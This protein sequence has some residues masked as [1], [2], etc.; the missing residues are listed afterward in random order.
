MFLG[1]YKVFQKLKSD[2]L[3]INKSKIKN[4]KSNLQF[5]IQKFGIIGA[6]GFAGI[7]LSHN[8]TALI[9][10]PFLIVTFLLFII[11]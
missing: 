4:Q 1:F 2:E 8:L 11:F 10:A 6:L 5:K 3:E 9:V 7:I